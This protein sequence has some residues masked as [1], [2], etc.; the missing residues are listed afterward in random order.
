MEA[1]QEPYC[2]AS[3]PRQDTIELKEI[4]EAAKKGWVF[5]VVLA[6]S[7]GIMSGIYYHVN[8]P[9]WSA[10]AIVKIGHINSIIN[11]QLPVEPVDDVV[12]WVAQ[13]AFLLPILKKI[14]FQADDK[15]TKLLKSSLT[16]RRMKE[17][18]NFIEIGLRASS[19]EDAQ[20]S[21]E[22][23]TN[24]LIDRHQQIVRS[25][26]LSMQRQANEVADLVAQAKLKQKYL[27]KAII[28]DR[29][30]LT[31]NDLL[32]MLSSSNGIEI[33]NLQERGHVLAS[34][35]LPP[36]MEETILAGPIEVNVQ[37]SSTREML[38]L[39]AILGGVLVGTL[40]SVSYFR[41]K[42]YFVR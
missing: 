15:K 40:L 5:I 30:V 1:T 24:A 27:T 25:F 19:R 20:R 21:L 28:S 32:A 35:V 12:V 26:I 10:K 9:F 7:F 22:E 14:G 8:S 38:V 41:I 6:C 42:R 31:A 3:S 29:G 4:V 34:L 11:P 18:S 37:S 33:L 16:V 36:N 13:D 2:V 39:I 17:Q 23:I